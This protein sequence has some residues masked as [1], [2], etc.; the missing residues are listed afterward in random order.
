MSGPIG[1]LVDALRQLGCDIDYL[2]SRGLSRRCASR[3]P[4][5]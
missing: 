5:R 1:D 3:R 4:A 2:G